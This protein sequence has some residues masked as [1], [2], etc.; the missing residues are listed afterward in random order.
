MLSLSKQDLAT[1]EDTYC[2][3][4]YLIEYES[5]LPNEIPA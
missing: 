2:N 4:K 1:W 5:T 3:L